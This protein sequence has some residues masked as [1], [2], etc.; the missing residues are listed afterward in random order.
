VQHVIFNL[1]DVH[2]V[3]NLETL[4][5]DVLPQVHAIEAAAI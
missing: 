5:R 3:R 2:D 1:S 4:G